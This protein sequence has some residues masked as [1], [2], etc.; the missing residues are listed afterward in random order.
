MYTCVGKSTYALKPAP[1]HP[2]RDET[3]GEGEEIVEDS[4]AYMRF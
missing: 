4:K 1:R 2:L 3:G